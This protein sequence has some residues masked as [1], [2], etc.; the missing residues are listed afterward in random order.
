MKN[1]GGSARSQ[2]RLELV[3]SMVLTAE[4]TGEAATHTSTRC[5][6]LVSVI[7]LPSVDYQLPLPCLDSFCFTME[8]RLRMLETALDSVFLK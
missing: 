8:L 5:L 7:L 3:L 2:A 1:S 6:L 4:K